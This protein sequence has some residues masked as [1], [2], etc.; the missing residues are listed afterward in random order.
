M[1][2]EEEN[3]L[4]C[5]E[6]LA[7]RK[8]VPRS[9]LPNGSRALWELGGATIETPSF[10]AWTTTGMILNH[11]ETLGI[12]FVLYCDETGWTLDIPV[13]QNSAPPSQN[14]G[15]AAIRAAALA[16][17]AIIRKWKAFINNEASNQMH[18]VPKN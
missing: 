13:L 10:T 18:G 3:E 4:I 8:T 12:G 16:A 5:E 17:V 15:P 14:T 6:F 1:T 2:T 7:W 11:L 9:L